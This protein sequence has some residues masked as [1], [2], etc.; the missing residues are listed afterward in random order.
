MREIISE[1]QHY[2]THKSDLREVKEDKNM[3]SCIRLTGPIPSIVGG[4][5]LT[6]I[7][8]KGGFFGRLILAGIGT[9]LLVQGLQ[10]LQTSPTSGIGRRK[11]KPAQAVKIEA[12]VMVHRRPDELFRFWRQFENLPRFMEEIQTVEILSPTRSRW[13]MTVPA[14]EHVSRDA[15]I[16]WEAEIINEKEHELIGW[17]SVGHSDVEHAGS[18]QFKPI[19]EGNS[20]EVRVTLQYAPIGGHIGVGILRM[21]GEDPQLKIQQN[22]MKF[23]ELMEAGSDT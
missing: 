6:W 13:I 15:T 23:K 5:L 14:I 10:G 3:R 21:F 19:D 18:V 9:G 4:G 17:R 20:T 1:K 16:E 11:I 2:S 22:L 12:A 8:L 7:G